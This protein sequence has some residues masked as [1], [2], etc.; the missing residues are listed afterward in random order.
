MLS[1]SRAKPT[2]SRGRALMSHFFDQFNQVLRRLARAPLFTTITLITLAVGIGANAVVF[3]VVE[4]VLL[5]PLAYPQ[6]DRLVGIWHAAPAIGFDNRN[7]AP[8]L[9]FIDREQGSTFEDV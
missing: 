3:S 2:A 7:M 8:F 5:K 4:S 6:A 9:Y 1:N